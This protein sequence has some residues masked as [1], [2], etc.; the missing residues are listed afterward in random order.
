MGNYAGEVTSVRRDGKGFK[1]DD[2]NWYSGFNKI[3]VSVGDQVSLAYRENVVRGVTYFNING[4]VSVEGGG[5]GSTAKAP[6][7]SGAPTGRFVFPIPARD[8]QRSII[9][10]NAMAHA[11][12]AIEIM[13]AGKDKTPEDALDH[14]IKLARK[15][16]SYTTGDMDAEMA[17][18]LADSA[19]D[20]E[21]KAELAS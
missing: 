6:A 1:G 8:S 17:A 13:G 9:R 20:S 15:V 11:M 18:K 21:A 14:A 3:D 4:A 2:G 16:E 5:S 7:K 12:K 19:A 10:Q